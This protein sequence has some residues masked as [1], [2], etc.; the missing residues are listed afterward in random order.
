MCLTTFVSVGQKVNNI[1]SSGATE[2]CK[3]SVAVTSEIL[4]WSNI[5]RMCD[6]GTGLNEICVLS[7]YNRLLYYCVH[8]AFC[9]FLLI[10]QL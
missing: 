5:I 6:Q 2:I 3:N 1:R 7:V 8:S 9:K 4:M 10:Y